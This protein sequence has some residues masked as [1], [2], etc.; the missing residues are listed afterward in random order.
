MAP[1]G[2]IGSPWYAISTQKFWIWTSND[3]CAVVI[4]G[5]PA[6]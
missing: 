3:C 1:N 2:L 4:G 5:G 6:G